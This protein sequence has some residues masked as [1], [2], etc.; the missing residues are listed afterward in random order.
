MATSAAPSLL[1]ITIR[2]NTKADRERLDEGLRRMVNEDATLTVEV[3]SQTDAVTVGAVSESQ[4]ETVIDRLKREFNV[5]AAVDRLRVAYREALTE[6]SDGEG[7]LSR[8][9]GGRGEYAHAKLRV[10]PGEPGSGFAFHNGIV[11][12]A[13]PDRFVES[14]REGIKEACAR[15]VVGGYP[16]IDVR[17]ELHD[18]SYHHLD[19]SESAFKAVGEMA[20]L[21]AAKKAGPVLLEPVMRVEVVTPKQHAAEVIANLLSRRGQIQSRTDNASGQI[22]RA[23][24]PLSE[25]FG[26]ATDLRSRTRGRATCSLQFDRYVR[27]DAEMNGQDPN[28]PVGAPLKPAPNRNDSAIALPEPEDDRADM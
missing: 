14:V 9:I 18:G 5:E 15:G 7:R 1:L 21:D 4:L 25:L 23:L 8:Q 6:R 20:L 16:L 24:V 13:I 12:E 3:D 28:L 27:F 19:S 2:A 10:F 22:V 17:A 26:Y 11:G